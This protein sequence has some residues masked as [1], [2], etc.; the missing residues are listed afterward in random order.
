MSC[1]LYFTLGSI[2]ISA[3]PD[4]LGVNLGPAWHTASPHPRMA[5]N[6]H[7]IMTSLILPMMSGLQVVLSML[8]LI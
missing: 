8:N 5:S 7:G 3:F 1:T 2:L 4:S 6:Y